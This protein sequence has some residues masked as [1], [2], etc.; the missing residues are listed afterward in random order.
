MKK[1]LLI[2]LCVPLIGIGQQTEKKDKTFDIFHHPKSKGLNF[3]VK[4]PINFEREDGRRPN[5]LYNWLKNRDNLE[6]RITISIAIKEFPEEVQLTKK[7]WVNYLKFESGIK[8]FTEGMNDLNQEKYIVV[9]SYPGLMFNYTN[10]VQRI[11]YTR[12]TFNTIII[13]IVENKMFNVSMAAS[14]K[15]SLDLNEGV[16]LSLINSLI[17]PDQYKN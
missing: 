15:S 17:F 6:N 10:E 2:L 7:E 16:F 1:L 4:E 5:I 9:E 3:S 14:N 8:D 13:L 11:D 12:K